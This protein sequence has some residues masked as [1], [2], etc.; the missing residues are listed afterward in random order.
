M[1]PPA[2]AKLVQEPSAPPVAPFVMDE[3]PDV[4]AGTAAP[5]AEGPKAAAEVQVGPVQTETVQSGPAEAAQAPEKTPEEEEKFAYKTW[6]RLHLVLGGGGSFASRVYGEAEPFNLAA[7]S[8]KGPMLFIQPTFTVFTLNPREEKPNGDFELRV[9]ADVKTHFLTNSPD[10]SIPDSSVT[11]LSVD[12]LVEGAYYVH[13]NFAV[14]LNGHIG[15]MGLISSNADVGAPFD[16]S[17]DWGSEGGLS[18]G[19]Q[20]FFGFWD[21]NI[22]L[23]F[24]VDSM[25][26]A[27]DLNAGEGNPALRTKMDPIIGFGLGV[28][29]I[30]IIRSLSMPESKST[31]G[32]KK[33]E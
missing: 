33:S 12:G 24:N 20:L 8:L 5:A 21:G 32:K 7:Q 30:G 15:R 2:D 4:S 19:G 3:G 10:Q 29:P 25:L 17:F 6:H 14:G 18:A 28:D 23:A 22:R 16:A 31:E 26:T 11:A 9:G 27:F 13:R 1:A